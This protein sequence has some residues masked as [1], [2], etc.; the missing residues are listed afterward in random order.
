[1]K[2]Y[3]R[4]KSEQEIKKD[5]PIEADALQT[6]PFASY[7]FN[8]DTADSSQ[9]AYNG[10]LVGSA[11]YVNDG[12]GG[13]V[14][15]SGTDQFWQNYVKLDDGILTQLQDAKGAYCDRLGQK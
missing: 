10:T 15:P 14:L 12:R 1:M 11:E 4:T 2:I 6:D 9:N 8:G 13:I 3:N 7:A 5:S